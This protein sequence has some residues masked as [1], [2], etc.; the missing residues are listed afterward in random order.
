MQT[1]DDA[2]RGPL[3]ASQLL[4]FLRAAFRTTGRRSASWAAW[5]AFITIAALAVDPFAQQILS[6][7][8]QPTSYQ[9]QSATI[10]RTG[11]YSTGVVQEGIPASEPLSKGNRY[12][13]SNIT[14]S[15]Y[16]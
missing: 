13:S 1:F 8:V 16:Y 9:S 3:G 11:L 10:E 7:P 4:G 5:G 6:F 2:S 14:I 12:K 15:Y